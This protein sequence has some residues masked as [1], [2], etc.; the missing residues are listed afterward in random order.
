MSLHQTLTNKVAIVFGGSRG[1]GAAIARR[2]ATDGADVALTYVSSS[3]K[4]MAVAA[5]IESTGRKAL[6]LKADSADSSAIQGA[7]KK[8]MSYFGKIDIAVINAGVLPL[9]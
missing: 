3:E 4:A 6:A 1:I 7:V 9:G 8:A 2:L 5:S